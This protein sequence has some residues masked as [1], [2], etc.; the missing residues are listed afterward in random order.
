VSWRGTSERPGSGVSS[1]TNWAGAFYFHTRIVSFLVPYWV[2]TFYILT[3]QPARTTK[4]AKFE[5]R[6]EVA[7]PDRMT[8]KVSILS[9]GRKLREVGGGVVDGGKRRDPTMSPCISSPKVDA[10]KR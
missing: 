8:I 10:A 2:N 5:V 9:A 4:S 7:A 1:G 3:R 6:T